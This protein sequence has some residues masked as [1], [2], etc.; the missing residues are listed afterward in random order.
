[1]AG[2]I[3]SRF[4][5]LSRNQ[6]P[7]QFLDILNTGKT[8]IQ[9]TYDRLLH[10]VPK[11]NIWVVSHQDY[12]KLI[13]E[14]LPEIKPEQILLE[15]ERKN[16]APCLMYASACISQKNPDNI[17]FIA[18]SDHLIVNESR[19][20]ED[21][22]SAFEFIETHPKHL[23]TFGIQATRP[24][25]GYG[26]IHFDAENNFGNEIFPVRQFVEKPDHNTAMNY[27]ENGQYVWNSGMFMWSGKNFNSEMKMNAPA[28]SDLFNT[29]D[30]RTD[31]PMIYKQ[32]ESISIDYALMEKTNHA[33]VKSVHFG[34]S[35]LGTW[36]SLYQLKSLDENQNSIH[37]PGIITDE[38]TNCLIENSTNQLM[39]I[40]GLEDF[41]VVNTTDVLLICQ[42]SSEQK[43]RE[44]V[45]KAGDFQ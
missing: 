23:L 45:K 31:I 11:E 26:Y 24:D 12:L 41:I 14:Q 20:I 44:L 4:W 5:P 43:I 8:L 15:P 10:C 33:V 35:D 28:L 37:G 18:S 25:T 7:K 29:K 3:G 19:F 34:W 9:M 38:T 17:Q 21:V 13:E 39:A 6:K 22:R 40:Q 2:G 36:G 42:K 1:M 16:T 32:C 30:V 27:L